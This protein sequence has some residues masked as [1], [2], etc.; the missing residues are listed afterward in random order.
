M[1]YLSP[2]R[3]R[4]LVADTESGDSNAFGVLYEHFRQALTGH[5]CGRLSGSEDVEDVVG[6]CFL[7]ALKAV[8]QGKF[9][10][11]Y[12]FYTFLRGIADNEVKRFLKRTYV[13]LPRRSAEVGARYVPK[14]LVIPEGS[15]LSKDACR[16]TDHMLASLP[17]GDPEAVASELLRLALSS[18]AKP[19]QNL[20]F[21][22][23]RF[24]EWRPREVVSELGGSAIL[25]IAERV[26]ESFAALFPGEEFGADSRQRH[27]A[28]FWRLLER[29]VADVYPEPEYERL[30]AVPSVR[31]GDL[32]LEVFFGPSPT[33]S[34]SDWCDKAR[35]RA[36][37]AADAD[38]SNGR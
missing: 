15:S 3:Q 8:R 18:P 16:R 33:A 4:E 29:P 23:I 22:L 28:G 37:K 35:R 19:H 1:Q 25:H 26:Y 6:D 17:P 32:P 7:L 30:R 36:R 31:A 13:P 34:L 14:V 10:P 38:M 24:L 11:Q 5:V 20:A 21:C 27:C 9:D 12:S 2:Q